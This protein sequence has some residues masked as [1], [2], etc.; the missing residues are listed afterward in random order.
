MYRDI[1]TNKW[2]ISVLGFLVMFGILCYFW[3]KPVSQRYKQTMSSA[4]DFLHQLEKK[5]KNAGSVDDASVKDITH[6]DG[7]QSTET[8]VPKKESSGSVEIKRDREGKQLVENTTE[9]MRVSPHGFGPYPEIPK[10]A[11]VNPFI[12]SESKN[13]EL[14][15][16]VVIKKWNEGVRF[17]GASIVD[18]IVYLN[19][20]D[21]VYVQYGDPIKNID[22]TITRPITRVRGAKSAFISE[23]Q[24]R[25][26]EIPAGIKV[27]EIG[28]DGIDAYTYLNLR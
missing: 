4:T 22:G 6:T 20:P 25:A 5:R 21:T 10:G 19:Y 17:K 11:P 13:K 24:M 9:N 12:G 16:R 28:K 15:K 3:Y 23:K 8:L 27:L 14:L 2:T 1:I 26:G 18:G 7:E